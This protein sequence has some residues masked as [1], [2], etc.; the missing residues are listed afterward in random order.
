MNAGLIKTTAAAIL[1]TVSVDA[2]VTQ[3]VSRPISIV[4]MRIEAMADVKLIV[5]DIKAMLKGR[6]PYSADAIR[7]NAEALKIH[8]S[9][10]LLLFPKG[11][12][13]GK[14][15]A[16]PQIWT[17]W[18]GF[19]TRTIEFHA[20]ALMLAGAADQELPAVKKAFSAVIRTC[21][22]CHDKFKKKK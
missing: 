11:S 14:T 18:P 12:G 16:L 4:T 9:Q 2:G 10:I 15:G 19:E 13:T 7:W 3:A 5:K 20:S 8:A 1:I 17:D 6:I 22:S 21:K